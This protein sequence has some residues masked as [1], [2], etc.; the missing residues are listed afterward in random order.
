MGKSKNINMFLID[1]EV[2]GTIKCTLSNWVGVIYKIPRTKLTSELVK[3]REELKQSGI[4]FLLG[5]DEET[6]KDLVY[7]GQ[8]GTRKNGEGLLLRILEH[9]RDNHSDYFNEVIILSTQNNLFGATEIS[10]LENK[11]TNLAKE[12]N[13]YIVRNGNEP[14]VGNVTEEKQSELDEIIENTKMIIGTLGHRMFIPILRTKEEQGE[15]ENLDNDLNLFL[16]RRS[17]KSNK[18]IKAQCKRT[19]EGFVVLK[20]SMIEL[21]NSKA[22]PKTIEE[23]RA[24]LIEKNIIK[25][26]VLMENQLFNSPSYASAFILGMN[27]NGRTDWKNE[28]GITLKEL[29]GREMEE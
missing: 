1:G 6:G 2:T 9:T 21:I 15:K 3:N 5:K 29:E 17:K 11:F 14:N 8:A 4:Y 12:A 19:D 13:R 25:D 10:Y 24:E 28:K 7:I 20:G 16:E 23:L 27:T 26:G 22:I 18:H